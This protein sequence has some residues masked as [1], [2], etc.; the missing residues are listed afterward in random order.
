MTKTLVA[1]AD[2]R[3]VLEV[4]GFRNAADLATMSIDD[5]RNTLIVELDARTA[6]SV[7]HY[8]ALDNSELAGVGAVL[9]IVRE[10]EFRTDEQ[11]RSVTDDGLR[12]LLIVETDLKCPL[13]VPELQ[14]LSNLS[15]VWV[16]VQA[17]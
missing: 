17:F 13:S 3:G 2:I 1:I 7:A 14:A 8:Q 11:L 10:K 15:L 9:V 5:Q 16:A 12:N 6:N 4:G